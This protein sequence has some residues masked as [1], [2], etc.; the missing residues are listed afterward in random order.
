MVLELKEGV[1]NLILV[2]CG[3]AIQKKFEHTAKSD[4]PSLKEKVRLKSKVSNL[5]PKLAEMPKKQ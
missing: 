3:V 1:S 2:E 4:K 5:S